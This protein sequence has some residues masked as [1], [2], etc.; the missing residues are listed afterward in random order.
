[1]E[2]RRKIGDQTWHWCTSCSAWPTIGFFERQNN[3]PSTDATALC[4]E[5]RV[6][7]LQEDGGSRD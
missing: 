1:V 7:D 4:N 5:C 6:K 3:F 2:Y